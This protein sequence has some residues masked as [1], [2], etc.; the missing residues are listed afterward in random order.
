MF[1]F[2]GE[3]DKK[4]F[5][6][7]KTLNRRGVFL[8]SSSLFSRTEYYS[9]LRISRVIFV[10]LRKAEE[11]GFVAEEEGEE[12]EEEEEDVIRVISIPFS[13]FCVAEHI[14]DFSK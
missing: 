6:L 5:L 10:L 14:H 13:F 11:D 1:F 12:E 7:N 3:R 8:S 2:L 9:A 4:F